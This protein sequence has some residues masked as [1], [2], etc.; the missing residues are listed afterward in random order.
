MQKRFSAVSAIL[1]FLPVALV[2]AQGFNID[3]HPEF[4][5]GDAISVGDVEISRFGTYIAM[6]EHTEGNSIRVFDG[7]MA[8]LWRRRLP[9]YWAGSLTPSALIAFAPDESAVVFPGARTDKDLCVCDAATGE[10][11]AVLVG[12]QSAVT[13][14][15]MSPDG[16]YL[17]T[18][19]SDELFLW[20][21]EGA[22]Y[23]L[24]WSTPDYEPSAVDIEFFPD[25]R[26]VAISSRDNR[27]RAI[28]VY[29]VGP[30]DVGER[31][32]VERGRFSLDDGH[33]SHDFYQLAISPDGATLAAGYR[34]DILVFAVEDEG[35]REVQRIEDID[36]DTVFSLTFSPDGSYLVSGHTRYLRFW[37]REAG[38]WVEA[39]IH[40]T[41]LAAANDLVFSADAGELYVAGR[42]DEN[43]LARFRVEGVPGSSFGLLVAA[44][45]GDLSPAQR[46]SF[47]DEVAG[48]IATDLGPDALAPRDM[49]ETE[50]EYRLRIEEARSMVT[51][52]LA[53]AVEAG[54]GATRTDG[55][56]DL[57]EVS[58]PLQTQGAY[59]IESERYV[60]RAFDA[61]AELVIPRDSARD[62]YRNWVD[63]RV[64]ATRYLQNGGARYADF[65]LLHPDGRNS[66]PLVFDRN[67]F[68]GERM[69]E[70]STLV[71]TIA[72]GSELLIRDLRIDALF[73]TLAERYAEEAFAAFVLENAGSGI[74]SDLRGSFELQ[75]LTAAPVP[76]GLPRSLAAGSTVAVDL[77]APIGP[78]ILADANGG[79]TTLRIAFSYRRGTRHEEHEISRQ[80]RVLNRN[81]V[82]WSDDRRIGAFMTLT[83]PVVVGWAAGVAG[84]ASV[85]PTPVLT[86]NLLYAMHIFEALALSGIEYVVDPNSAYQSLSRDDRAVDYLRFPVETMVGRAGDCDDLSVLYAT[87]LEAVGVSTAF[88]T[89]PGHIFV[90][91]DTG[92]APDR[93]RRTFESLDDL[94][95]A[96]G[97]TWMPIETTLLSEGFAR[98]W[99]TGALQY[100]Q[101]VADGTAGFFTSRAAWRIYGPVASPSVA[102]P[103]PPASDL[104]GP[105]VTVGLDAFRSVELEPKL[106]RADVSDDPASLNR[107]GILLATYGLN[108]QAA[109]RFRD[110]ADR[111]HV[112]SLVNLS[113]VLSLEGRHGEAQASL[114][115]ASRRDPENA[116]ILLGL[117]LA[118]REGGDPSR[119][120]STFQHA[121]RISPSLAMRYPL[122]GDTN[123]G[124]Q[125]A[126]GGSPG[127]AGTR[128]G[129]SDPAVELLFDWVEE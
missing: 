56:N 20:E 104:V 13:R 95:F 48:A 43:G 84:A 120:R 105:A 34:D 53:Q 14:L 61:A 127:D 111:G 45:D 28:V 5:L 59:E 64:V 129:H 7:D 91:F 54:Y 66:Y 106:A 33:L 31:G 55:T 62:L 99:R 101:A 15:G 116:R 46:R 97:A 41:Q 100:R 107:L 44:L 73:P 125:V 117:A 51:S 71:P 42:N 108:D 118:Y 39:A 68:T 47:T 19:G 32:L 24:R 122:F 121:S 37:R 4:V 58:V 92:I 89:T 1:L 72:I 67:P 75:G 114:E 98:S 76:L 63:A 18:S 85:V 25:G 35:L 30:S 126:G 79:M 83:D 52:R 128:A 81:A 80:V 102:G 78:Q 50:E 23:A 109:D 26:R 10:T 60:L 110:A 87:L 21:R 103:Q 77:R 40:P 65:R 69:N 112:P 16:R 2:C 123:A 22:G 82:Q 49:F 38:G 70:A 12:H 29:E 17:M 3:M 9:Y 96:D 74:L 115:E 27:T 86:R 8:P 6:Y 88:I 94:V 113:N 90:A 124:G 93:A 57:I 36:V 11:L 119:A